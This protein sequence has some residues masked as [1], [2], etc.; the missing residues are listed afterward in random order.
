MKNNIVLCGFMGCG[1]STV[2][3]LLAH[4]LG[5][6]FCDTDEII[7]QR[8]NITITE[9]FECKG[10]EYFRN[11]ETAVITELSQKS[12]LIISTGGGAMLRR[13][14]AD[15]LKENGLIVFLDV[16]PETVVERL[17]GDTSRPL[18]QRPD[19]DSA[20]ARLLEERRPFYEYAAHITVNSNYEPQKIISDILSIYSDKA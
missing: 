13:K 4:K 6:S 11:A 8:E 16:S 9:I 12:G 17:K 1:K 14:N 19:R 7:E 5:L 3:R 15:A 20:I 18:L 10:E 2:G